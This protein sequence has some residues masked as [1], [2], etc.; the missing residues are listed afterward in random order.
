MGKLRLQVVCKGCGR[1]FDTGLVMDRRSF[2]QGTLAANYHACPHCGQ[3]LTY[4]K[5]EY[6]VKEELRGPRAP[7]H[8]PR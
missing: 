3:R 2:E 7:G 5:A 4:K 6:I 1:Q 8:G